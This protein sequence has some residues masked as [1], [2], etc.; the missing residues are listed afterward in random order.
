M[1]KALLIL[2]FFLLLNCKNTFINVKFNEL[3][4]EM[5]ILAED[6]L[7]NDQLNLYQLDK[8]D[9]EKEIDTAS[10]QTK[11]KYSQNFTFKEK[12]IGGISSSTY[13]YSQDDISSMK[14]YFKTYILGSNFEESSSESIKYKRT[15]KFEIECDD[16]NVY[17]IYNSKNRLVGFS[18]NILKGIQIIH[19]SIVL[20]ENL[21]IDQKKLNKKIFQF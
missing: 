11:F 6:I 4:K 15:S 19:T 21:N 8:P 9:F 5:L 10:A 12:N 20:N 16:Y 14:F 7:L 2:T 13:T 17:E 3:D 18:F 1:K